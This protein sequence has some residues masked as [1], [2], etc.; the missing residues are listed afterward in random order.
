MAENILLDEFHALPKSSKDEMGR[1]SSL[2]S[3]FFP[4]TPV[5]K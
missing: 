1:P 5:F 2:P 4:E 3:D